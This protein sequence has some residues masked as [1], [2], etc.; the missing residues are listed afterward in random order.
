M[1]NVSKKCHKNKFIK[2]K[3]TVVSHP[4]IVSVRNAVMLIMRSPHI[5]RLSDESGFRL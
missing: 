3:Y 5:I 2:L 4:E 1:G